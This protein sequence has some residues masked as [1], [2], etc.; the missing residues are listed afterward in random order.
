MTA[1]ARPAPLA[2]FATARR[3]GVRWSL[4]SLA[5]YLRGRWALRGATSVGTV[6]LR[7]RAKLTNDGDTVIG[8]RVRLDG[9]VTRL[10]FH[11]AAGASLTIGSGTF[12]NYGTSIGALE[13]VSIGR[14]CDIGQYAIILD[15]NFHATDDHRAPAPAEPVVI[16]D[17]VWLGA[18]VTVLPGAHIGRGAVIGAHAVVRGSIPSRSLAVGVPAKVVRKLDAD[19]GGPD[20]NS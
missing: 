8:D 13:S 9:T 17:D 2:A 7:G 6:R 3:R 14:N 20:G 11:C 15:N 4:T 1:A 12:I 18:R 10:D 19:G 5:Q 16:E